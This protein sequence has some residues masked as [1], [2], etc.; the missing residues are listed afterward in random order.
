MPT[1]LA[2]RFFCS[3]G[4]LAAGYSLGR[5]V[6]ATNGVQ[7]LPEPPGVTLL[8]E[9]KESAPP[10]GGWGWAMRP[11]VREVLEEV[12]LPWLAGNDKPA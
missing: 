4:R 2:S 7:A 12:G 10:G 8:F 9:Q 11:I 1:H 5:R 3:G 6:N